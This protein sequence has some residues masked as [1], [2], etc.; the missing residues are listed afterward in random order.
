MSYV[1]KRVMEASVGMRLSGEHPTFKSQVRGSRGNKR[2]QRKAREAKE[3][4]RN[5]TNPKGWHGF[6]ERMILMFNK[7]KTEIFSVD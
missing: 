7:M 6:K 2:P 5:V 4:G 3:K 1:I